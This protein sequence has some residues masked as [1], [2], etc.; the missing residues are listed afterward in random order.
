S[1]CHCPYQMPLPKGGNCSNTLGL[2]WALSN[3]SSITPQFKCPGIDSYGKLTHWCPLDQFHEYTQ[4]PDGRCTYWGGKM[5]V[6]VALLKPGEKPLAK[7]PPVTPAMQVGLSPH[8]ARKPRLGLAT[9][10]G[11]STPQ[12]CTRHVLS[13]GWGLAYP[14]LDNAQF[15]GQCMLGQLSS[16]NLGITIHNITQP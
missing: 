13:L 11:G 5:P 15:G 4:E 3:A 6:Y 14:C 2:H 8:T 7:K 10:G 1:C 9:Y 16:Q 12:K